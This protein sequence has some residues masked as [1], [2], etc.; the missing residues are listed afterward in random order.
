MRPTALVPLSQRQDKKWPSTL[1]DTAI[2][3]SI[4]GVGGQPLALGSLE[5]TYG[6]MDNY[7]SAEGLAVSH[8]GAR[9]FTNLT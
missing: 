8:M 7:R 9:S 6:S 2:L 1:E 3:G 5:Y 4:P